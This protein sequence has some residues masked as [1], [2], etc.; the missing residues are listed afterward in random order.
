MNFL[1][2]LPHFSKWISYLKIFGRQKKVGDQS[3]VKVQLFP[4]LEK[5]YCGATQSA[6][7][8]H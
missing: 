4:G 2:Y 7:N 6:S 3:E 5:N 1:P 8:H